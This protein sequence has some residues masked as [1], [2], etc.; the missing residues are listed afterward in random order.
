MLLLEEQCLSGLNEQNWYFFPVLATD[1]KKSFLQ[2]SFI[3][4]QRMATPRVF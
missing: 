1:M 4:N 3:D 2:A